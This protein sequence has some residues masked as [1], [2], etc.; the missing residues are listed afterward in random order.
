LVKTHVADGS[1]YLIPSLGPSRGRTSVL[2]ALGPEM[3]IRFGPL[4][5]LSTVIH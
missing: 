3:L 1:S 4:I 2:L 5:V